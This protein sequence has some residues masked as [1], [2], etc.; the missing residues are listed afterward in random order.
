MAEQRLFM[1]ACHLVSHRTKPPPLNLASS[2]RRMP[3]HVKICS[4]RSPGCCRGNLQPAL[5]RCYWSRRVCDARVHLWRLFQQGSSKRRQCMEAA[6]SVCIIHYKYSVHCT[7]SITANCPKHSIVHDYDHLPR[8]GMDDNRKEQAMNGDTNGAI[9]SVLSLE[10]LYFSA[11]HL[12]KT[13]I[14]GGLPES[15]RIFQAVFKIH[16]HLHC[17]SGCK[18]KCACETCLLRHQNQRPR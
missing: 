16:S 10:H 7:S 3:G 8:F 5:N 6:L 4:I 15:W 17:F 18:I 1:Q 2:M 11:Q 12:E 9:L 14:I 13:A